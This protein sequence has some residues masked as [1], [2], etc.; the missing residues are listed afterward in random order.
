MS[1]DAASATKN[2]GLRRGLEGRGR[3]TYFVRSGCRFVSCAADDLVGFA[4]AGVVLAG[5][6]SVSVL[7]EFVAR[8]R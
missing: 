7:I 2:P 3:V 8:V 4:V 5:A 1:I 6:G